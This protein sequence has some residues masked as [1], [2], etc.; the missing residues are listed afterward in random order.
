MIRPTRQSGNSNCRQAGV[1]IVADHPCDGDA[2]IVP[3][4]KT[5]VGG[6]GD[7]C[8]G[9]TSACH[10]VEVLEGAV[11]RSVVDDDQ[12][13]RRPG[14]GKEAVDAHAGVLELISGEHNDAGHWIARCRTHDV[15]VRS[16]FGVRNGLGIRVGF[17][18]HVY[19]PWQFDRCGFAVR[20][21]SR[22]L[23]GNSGCIQRL[24]NDGA[25]EHKKLIG[26]SI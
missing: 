14:V 13:E 8:D 10:G 4:T 1:I 2:L 20:R 19:N 5:E 3:R 11:G 25:G 9:I 7:Q 24:S 15:G 18:D 16:G 17:L 22:R 23:F 21:C 26:L 12:F 6:I